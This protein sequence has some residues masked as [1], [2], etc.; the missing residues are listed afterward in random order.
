MTHSISEERFEARFSG[1]GGQGVILAGAILAEAAAFYDGKFA[2]QS[3]TYT[4]QVRGGPTKVDVIIS[5]REIIYPRSLKIDFFLALA[6]EAY[7]RFG[8][9][10][11]PSAIVLVDSNLVT[12]LEETGHRTYRL[13]FI[14][15]A[16]KEFGKVVYVNAIAL[17]VSVGLTNVVSRPAIEKAVGARAPKGTEEMNLKAL[18]LGFEKAKELAG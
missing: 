10:L 5:N 15:L 14:E 1:V 16:K 8:H 2:I 7:D 3:P 11:K 18:E 13:P 6:Q 12:R 17:G 9:D 4:A